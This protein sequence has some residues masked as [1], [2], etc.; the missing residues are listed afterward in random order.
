[1]GPDLRICEA[2]HLGGTPGGCDRVASIDPH[3]QRGAKR[4]ASSSARTEFGLRI[5]KGMVV[6]PPNTRSQPRWVPQKGR[7]PCSTI[8]PDSTELADATGE[9]SLCPGCERCESF[10]NEQGRS[11]KGVLQCETHRAVAMRL[12]LRCPVPP[13][14]SRD[15]VG[16]GWVDTLAAVV[17]SCQTKQGPRRTAHSQHPAAFSPA[18]SPFRPQKTSADSARPG[19]GKKYLTSM[20][21]KSI[22]ATFGG[23]RWLGRF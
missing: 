21:R 13:A 19:R 5:R 2:N 1:M 20:V 11:E 17:G 3:P 22:S 14:N 23:F 8:S 18:A 7:Y 4:S 6:N 16:I 15:G 10:T 9:G 12:G